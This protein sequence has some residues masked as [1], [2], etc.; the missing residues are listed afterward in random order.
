MVSLSR[1][2]QQTISSLPHLRRA[3]LWLIVSD[4]LLQGA[5]YAFILYVGYCSISMLGSF[6]FGAALGALLA[7]LVDFGINQ[8]WIRLQ[9]SDP[10]LTRPTFTRVFLAKTGLSMLGMAVLV[11][12]AGAGLWSMALIPAMAAGLLLATLQ[13]LAETCEA[14]ALAR[15]RYRLVSVFR[16]LLSIAL[17][18]VPLVLGWVL[19]EQNTEAGISIA[20]RSASIASV[21]MLCVYACYMAGSLPSNSIGPMGYR[22]AW[23]DARWLGLNQ[24]AIVVDVRAPF[25]IMGFMLGEAAV[26]LYGLVQRTTAIVELAWASISKLLLKSYAETAAANGGKDVRSDILVASKLTG[27]IMAGMTVLVWAISLYAAQVMELSEETSVALSLL[28]WAL[29]AISFSSLKRPLIAGLL[30]LYQERAVCRINVYSAAVGLVL[31]P[32]LI[33]SLGIWGP[34]IGWMLLEAAACLLLV[35]HFLSVP[36]APRSTVEGKLAQRVGI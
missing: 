26:G 23:W 3:A 24:T 36:Q 15:H 19:A 34:V 32:L 28:R 12:L 31:I 30:A 7:V 29:V 11:G 25:V 5:R 35:R 10:A 13:G 14:I 8:H 33:L 27:F 2:A 17:Y 22:G 20:L 21:L 1:F 18:G 16:S 4:T 9:G 6:L